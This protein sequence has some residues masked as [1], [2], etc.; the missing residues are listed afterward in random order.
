[1]CHSYINASTQWDFELRIA[2]PDA[3]QPNADILANGHNAQRVETAS[4]AVA[5]ADLVVT[6]VWSSMGHEGQE[7]QRREI[8]EPYQVNEALLDQA[9][10][11]VLFMHCLPA[12]RGEEVSATLPMIARLRAA[13][14]RLHSQKALVEFLPASQ[15]ANPLLACQSLGHRS[16]IV[17]Q[18]PLRFPR[19][20]G[21]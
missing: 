20:S 21:Q 15:R 4:E 19:A 7:A 8:F 6:D 18:Q 13:G 17:V 10:S 5:D 16:G 14:N 2:C 3:H 1:M 12:H 9:K 11:D